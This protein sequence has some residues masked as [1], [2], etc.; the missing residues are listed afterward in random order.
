MAVDYIAALD[1]GTTSSR[2]ILFDHAGRPVASAQREHRQLYPQPGWVEHDPLEIW[3]NTR[4]LIAEVLDG[5]AIRPEQ[6]GA[7]GVTNQRE[8]TVLWHR[9]S[10]EPLSNAIVWQ[11]TRTAELCA[12]LGREPGIE[13]IRAR[14]GLP[15]ATYFSGPK[16]RWILDN[17]PAARD[18]H[19]LGKACFGTM[20]SWIIWNLTGG[21]HVTDP[22][23]ASRT[24]L[25]NI[26]ALDWDPELAHW[27][28]VSGTLLPQV[29]PSSDPR[30]Y[31][32]VQA[33]PMRGIPVC[34]AL[35][36]QQ[37]A[38]FGQACFEPGEAK[39]TYGTG[40]FLLLNTGAEAV[41]SRHGLLTT[42]AW[43]LGDAPAQYALEGAIAI[44]GSLVQWSRDQLQLFASAADLD[45]WAARAADNG[46]VY[47]VPAF[48]GLFAPHWRPDARGLV[49]GLT[50]FAGKAHLARAILEA[51]AYQTRDIFEAMAKDSGVA[52]KALKVDGGMTASGLLMQFQ[53]DI[54]GVPVTLPVVAETTA[55]GAAYAAGLASGF[56]SGPAELKA[57]WALAAQWQPAMDEAVRERLCS[58]WNKAVQR[59]LGWE[60]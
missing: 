49:A 12:E 15:V 44:A 24:L 27:L 34:A 55:L 37:A 26:H 58:G 19:R 57:N 28:G 43:Q 40:C 3:R 5:G 2:C 59:S 39:N 35:G 10:G 21:A 23:N 56:W 29:R 53:A 46:G 47:V 50:H 38:L 45:A 14:T 52:L 48:S 30:G 33:G 31:G 42:V 7:L 51:T 9:D 54:L 60:G 17:V 11:D 22:S 32:R 8:T 41:P 16:L 25:F 1:L 20:D 6:I 13:A 4:E 18:A 36:D